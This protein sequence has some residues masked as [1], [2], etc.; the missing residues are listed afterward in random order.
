[1]PPSPSQVDA[2]II[3]AG[4]TGL[5]IGLELAR[6]GYKV[7]YLARD[8]PADLQSTGFASPWAVSRGT[9]HC[10]FSMGRFPTDIRS[11]TVSSFLPGS[12][13]VFVCW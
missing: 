1:M 13:L 11:T 9:V 4:V 8:L 2:I 5:S 3:G 12:K 7:G 6:R 10:C